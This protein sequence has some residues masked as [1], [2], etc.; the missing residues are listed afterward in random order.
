MDGRVTISTANDT[1]ATE[2]VLLPLLVIGRLK[3]EGGG[4]G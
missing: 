1:A 3:E 4:W 2:E